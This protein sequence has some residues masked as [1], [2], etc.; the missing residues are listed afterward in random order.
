MSFI[1]KEPN[2][3]KNNKRSFVCNLGRGRHLGLNVDSPNH[4]NNDECLD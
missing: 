4:I 2:N 1:F 3:M